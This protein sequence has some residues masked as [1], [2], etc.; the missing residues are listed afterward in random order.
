MAGLVLG[1]GVAICGT[2]PEAC[3]L[4]VLGTEMAFRSMAGDGG[5]D[6]KGGESFAASPF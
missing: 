3:A 5:D 1:A 6:L 2:A 4:G